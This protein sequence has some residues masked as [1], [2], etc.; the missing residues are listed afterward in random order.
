[1]SEI[2]LDNQEKNYYLNIREFASGQFEAVMKLVKPMSSEFTEALV[3][4]VPLASPWDRPVRFTKALSEEEEAEKRLVNH[5]RSLRRSKQTVR[6]I[7]KAMEVDRLLTLTYREN[8]QDRDRCHAHFKDFLRRVR[9]Q[10]PGWR[11]VAV[12]E[13]QGRGALHIHC[14]VKGFQR[15]KFIRKCWYQALGG[16]GDETGADTPGA[17]NVTSPTNRWGSGVREWKTEKLA[18]YITKYIAKTFED[19]N[20]S[21]SEKRRYW[22]SKGTELPPVRRVWVAGSN[23]FEAIKNCLELLQLDVGIREVDF[24][25]WLSPENDSLWIAGRSAP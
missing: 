14:A 1:M 18:G 8:M 23:I 19:F 2:L 4:G 7:C 12:V 9:L 16:T 22:A 3:D 5:R 10:I 11:Y 17:V 20:E 25:W 24:D 6:F 15:I 13:L 21:L